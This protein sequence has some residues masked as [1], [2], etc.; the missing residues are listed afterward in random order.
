[1]NEV[2]VM[3]VADLTADIASSSDKSTGLIEQLV[4]TPLLAHPLVQG[5]WVAPTLNSVVRIDEMTME[6]ILSQHDAKIAYA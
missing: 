5:C 3:Q 4:G 1:M 6:I 2:V